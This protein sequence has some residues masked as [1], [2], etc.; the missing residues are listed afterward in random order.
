MPGIFGMV[1][2]DSEQR[3]RFY[4]ICRSYSPFSYAITQTPDCHI[5]SHAFRGKGIVEDKQRIVA[6]DGEFEIYQTLADSADLL[7]KYNDVS[8]S[9]SQKCKG[10][11]CVVDKD[12]GTLYLATDL[13]GCF[14]LYYA[15]TRDAF[16]FSSRL[17]SLGKY[18]ADKHDIA[19]IAEF[20]LGGYTFDD[21]TLYKNIRCV[22]P[23]EVIK[24]NLQSLEISIDNY[25]KLWTTR[26]NTQSREKLID[27][28]SELLKESIDLHPRTLLMMS[29]GWD[30]RTILAAG[31]A[32]NKINQFLAYSH[33]DLL[34]R[35]LG[36]VDRISRGM[37][38]SLVTQSIHADMYAMDALRDNLRHTEN[39]I[40]PYW[41]WAGKRANELGV[42]QIT[43][44][45]YGEAFG[46]HYGPP[47]V[48]RGAGKIYS[49]GKYLLN[50]PHTDQWNLQ[51]EEALQKALSLLKRTNIRKPWFV[52]DEFWHEIEQ[53]NNTLNQ[54]IESVLRRYQARGIATPENLI[55]AFVTEHRGSRYI[56]AQLLSCR[57]QVDVCLPFADR[58]FIEFATTLPFEEKVHNILNQAVIKKI[59]PE[60]LEFPMAATL[61]SAKHPIILQEASRAARK[62]L[63][64]LKWKA[65]RMSKGL[66]SEPR[67]G[68]VNFQFLSNNNN[69]Y[70]VIDSLTQPY[71]D[72]KKMQAN[73]R[74][75]S[76][77]S[78]HPTSDM[79]MKIL[80]I[81]HCL[82]V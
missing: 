46:G 45:V 67:L 38:I 54:D 30:S 37:N 41:H 8:I 19:G 77:T 5:G 13:L 44:G 79:L 66:I 3:N 55:E 12:G 75:L 82:D 60:L 7:Y 15:I 33:G 81:D 23:G 29:A 6:V 47:M 36:I 22:R 51:P 78:L 39:A 62:I 14:P 53:I 40:F 65:H 35:E 2:R 48:L 16:I 4:E 72:K 11:L 32:N 61:L 50:L 52:A 9:V 27:Q 28:A 56:T 42:Q 17:K 49:T 31:M 20:F 57:H 80:T 18:L 69:L 58:N 64:G 1:S 63:E 43:A 21:R 68:W 74:N 25:S 24:I 26:S 71:W 73:L 34:S 59:A 76:H 70:D 10:N